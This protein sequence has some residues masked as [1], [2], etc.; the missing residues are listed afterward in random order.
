RTRGQLSV[1]ECALQRTVDRPGYGLRLIR[2]GPPL[3]PAR[4]SEL[5]FPGD[6]EPENV[7]RAGPGGEPPGHLQPLLV[8]RGRQ[9]V[10]VDRVAPVALRAAVV[11]GLLDRTGM[12]GEHVEVKRHRAGGRAT[13]AAGREPGGGQGSGYRHA[14]VA[15]TPSRR[16]GR[17][18]PD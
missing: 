8:G 12:V 2:A 7:D 18:P 17:R 14:D 10:V 11:R 6:V 5:G 3:D 4:L 1:P 9:N 15:D 16:A 13:R